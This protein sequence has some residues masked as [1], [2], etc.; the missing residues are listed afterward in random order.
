[1]SFYEIAR[2]A[3]SMKRQRGLYAAARFLKAARVSREERRKLLCKDAS[4]VGNRRARPL[5]EERVK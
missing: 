2:V 3:L 4:S 5:F 1:M